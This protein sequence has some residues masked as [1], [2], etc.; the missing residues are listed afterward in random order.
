MEKVDDVEGDVR[1]MWRV[2]CEKKNGGEEVKK[3][4]I[5]FGYWAMG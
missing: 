3:C 4:V 5:I 2:G 1:V